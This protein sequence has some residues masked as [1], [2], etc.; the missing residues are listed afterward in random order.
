MW[1]VGDRRKIRILSM[2]SKSSC[3]ISRLNCRLVA[4]GLIPVLLLI[5]TSPGSHRTPATARNIRRSKPSPIISAGYRL[6]TNTR[7]S[8][9]ASVSPC[10]LELPGLSQ[11]RLMVKHAS[12]SLPIHNRQVI[13]FTEEP[14]K[15]VAAYN[16]VVGV[17]VQALSNASSIG[18]CRVPGI[19][20][21]R[22]EHG[23]FAIPRGGN[24][25]DL[26]ETT[27]L[28]ADDHLRRDGQ[29]RGNS[30]RA[31]TVT[32]IV[33]VV[34]HAVQAHLTGVCLSD[35]WLQRRGHV[36]G[37]DDIHACFLQVGFGLAQKD[38][39]VALRPV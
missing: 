14:E 37:I 22:D 7:I 38:R 23:R 4:M 12:S 17:G 15:L 36:D 16:G 24:L 26:L 3:L 19:Q 13:G 11:R 21:Y 2:L 39:Q 5:K 30:R 27:T 28:I 34:E 31:G 29:S 1:R 25:L 33:I 20:Q 9:E 8:Q 10:K 6:A 35:C 32:A 18:R